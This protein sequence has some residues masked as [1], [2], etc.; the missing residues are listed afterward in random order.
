[1]ARPDDPIS[2][3]LALA[4]LALLSVQ[5][6]VLGALQARGDALTYDE[7]IT[8]A[9]GW[10]GLA[11]H[12]L[13][14]NPEHP[15]LPKLLAALPAALTREL[16]VPET[17]SSWQRGAGQEL[18]L[19]LVRASGDDLRGLTFLF[20]IVPLLEALGVGLLLYALGS[21]LFGRGA[22]LLSATLWL[23][24]PLAVGF[25]HIDG[26]DVPAAGSVLLALLALAHQLERP[27]PVR[28]LLL[29]L[30]LGVAL[31]TRA[32]VGLVVVAVVVLVLG[33]TPPWGRG[34]S[35]LRA[36]VAAA[37]AWLVL[38]GAYLALDPGGPHASVIAP[39]PAAGQGSLPARLALLVPWPGGFEA[40]I[41]FMT[42]FHAQGS[43]PGYL[44]GRGFEGAPWWFWPGSLL[45]GLTPVTLLALVAGLSRFGGLEPER[46]RRAL[47]LLAP[48]ALGLGAL[49][50]MAQR[51][52]GVRYTIP[53]ATLLMLAAGP[54]A[55]LLRGRWGRWLLAAALALQLGGLW[56]SH[57]HSLAR[58]SPLFPQAWRWGADSNV[59][60]G[61][62]FHRLQAWAQDKRA[63]WISWFGFGPSTSL[64]EIP[65]AV[66]A[67]PLGVW[68]AF[69]PPPPDTEWVVVSASNLN[70]YAAEDLAWLRAW[71]PVDI[72]G[73]TMLVYRFEA[74]PPRGPAPQPLGLPEP[75]CRDRKYS[76]RRPR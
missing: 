72:I 3:R 35:A 31:L 33:L 18:A 41:R 32:G 16:P 45:L 8:M 6:L 57:P 58:T 2:P 20:R 50:L 7:P 63:P 13:R 48:M 76:E 37:L 1:M 65:G 40:S 52:Y 51:P 17:A 69:R 47:L 21:H 38:H 74:L 29:G 22:G 23:T 70:A 11:W 36:L 55:G 42:S 10:T 4:C 14:I 15:P 73:A 19:E 56:L 53:L 54:A 59:D 67:H 9:S 71:C 30:G 24:A 43:A 49:L 61:Q 26:L 44:F 12:D 68:A 75:L 46:R 60:W 39:L 64:E 34:R 5:F 62:D 27:G 66:S 28:L 25:G